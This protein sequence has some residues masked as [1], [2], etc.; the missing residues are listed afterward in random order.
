[1]ALVIRTLTISLGNRQLGSPYIT[2]S[3][4]KT[5]F[6]GKKILSFTLLNIVNVCMNIVHLDLF[7]NLY[8]EKMRVNDGYEKDF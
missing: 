4:V 3:N 1:M 7:L 8:Q 6:I 5:S 2:Y